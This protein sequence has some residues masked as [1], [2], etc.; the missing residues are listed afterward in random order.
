MSAARNEGDTPRIVDSLRGVKVVEAAGGEHH[1]LCV[2]DAGAVYSFG[3]GDYGERGTWLG[4]WLGHGS[5]DEERLPTRITGLHG[6]RV[7]AVAAGARHSLVLTD[8]GVVYSFGAGDGG[9]LG[10]GDTSMQWVPVRVRGL[11]G[12]VAA[13]SAGESHSLC[14]L[15][16]GGGVFGWGAGPGVGADSEA[17]A[18]SD[19]ADLTWVNSTGSAGNYEWAPGDGLL[20]RQ[21]HAPLRLDLL[22]A[23]PADA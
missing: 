16:D 20:A 9:K 18:D 11:A 4:G 5:L 7:L 14:A 2:D 3:A 17:M 12:R 6:R 13:V 8:G 21:A 1:S 23:A 10:H 19:S 22:P 15:K